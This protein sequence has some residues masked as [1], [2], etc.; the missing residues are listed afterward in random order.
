[1]SGRAYVEFDGKRIDVDVIDI[2][3]EHSYDMAVPR[4]QI[5]GLAKEFSESNV[6]RKESE[7]GY[8]REDRCETACDG[9]YQPLAKKVNDLELSDDERLLRK[10]RVVAQDGT[11]TG[12]GSEVLLNVLFKDNKAAVVKALKALEEAEKK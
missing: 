1:M 11:L 3:F 2:T 9:E 8:S 10:Y 5:N 6:D 4:V 7:M 12:A